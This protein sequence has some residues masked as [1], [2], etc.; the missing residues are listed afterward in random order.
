MSSHEEKRKRRPYAARMPVEQRRTELLDAALRVVA[1]DGYGALT[2]Q[3]I[4]AEA[5]VT[6]P[7]LYGAFETLPALLESLLDREEGKAMGQL[8]SVLPFMIFGDPSTLAARI[9]KA[10]ADAVRREPVTWRLILAGDG[11]APAAL[12]ARIERARAALRAQVASLIATYIPAEKA[13][14]AI[15]ARALIATAEDFGRL[16]VSTPEQ[17]DVER[18]AS[19]VQ[20]LVT[21]VVRGTRA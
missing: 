8:T 10:W 2:A 1:R 12:T 20:A 15:L 18:L 7:V 6:K 17:V 11:S 21:G 9:T 5:G 13:D 14:P 4:A 16:L 3:A 19:T